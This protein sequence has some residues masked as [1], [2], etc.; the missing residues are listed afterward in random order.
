MLIIINNITN[1]GADN[2]LVTIRIT[3]KLS[4]MAFGRGFGTMTSSVQSQS[5]LHSEFQDIQD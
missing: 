3:R 5:N 2:I 4:K 1:N